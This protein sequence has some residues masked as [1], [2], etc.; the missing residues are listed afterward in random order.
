MSAPAVNAQAIRAEVAELL[1]VDPES[2][3][4][5]VA[6]DGRYGPYVTEVLPEP[7]V[8]PE[9]PGAAPAKKAKKPQN[10]EVLL[11]KNGGLLFFDTMAIPVDAPRPGNAHKFI[12]YI[13]RP[14]VHASLTN[15]VFYANPNQ[16]SIKYVRK[17]IAENK[18]V[19]L[20]DADKQRL[21]D[22]TPGNY[23]GKAVELAKRV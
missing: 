14:E 13:L 6:K 3:H 12:N 7:I 20:P 4:E 10:L 18:T 19:F 17:D 8:P 22:M 9:D 1:G 11:P 5:I 15:K 2:G 23:I 16:A 21:L